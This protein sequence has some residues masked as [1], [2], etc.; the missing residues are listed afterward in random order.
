MSEQK[1]YV[2][3]NVLKGSINKRA[4]GYNTNY[5]PDY[6]HFLCEDGKSIAP[7]F[8]RITE[9]G[10]VHAEANDFHLGKFTKA[11]L[12]E[13]MDGAFYHVINEEWECG[14]GFYEPR[15]WINPL[16]ELVPVEEEK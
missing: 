7:C 12:S 4:N 6:V 16:I 8:E 2:K 14:G 1:Y 3:L 9:W 13:I 5:H 10:V 11:E 15:E